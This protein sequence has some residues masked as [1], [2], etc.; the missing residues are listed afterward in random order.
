[1]IEIKPSD[2]AELKGLLAKDD[3]LGLLK[4]LNQ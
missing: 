2:P 3:Y 1:M 4:G